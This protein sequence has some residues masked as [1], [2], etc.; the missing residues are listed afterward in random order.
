LTTR[1][2][3]AFFPGGHPHTSG[4]ASLELL[5]PTYGQLRNVLRHCWILNASCG[6]FFFPN[7]FLARRSDSTAETELSSFPR[8]NAPIPLVCLADRSRPRGVWGGFPP[9]KALEGIWK[10]RRPQ[11]KRAQGGGGSSPQDNSISIPASDARETEGNRKS[12]KNCIDTF[13]VFFGSIVMAGH[14]RSVRQLT[15]AFMILCETYVNCIL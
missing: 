8:R 5:S 13:S 4:L 12:Y 15:F 1:V 11:T 9:R 3:S 14:N 7:C 2:H 6:P 10:V